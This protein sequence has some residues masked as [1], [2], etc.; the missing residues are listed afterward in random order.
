MA[1]LGRTIGDLTRFRREWTRLMTGAALRATL[2][3]APVQGRL[4][5]TA[6]FGSNPG[7]LRMFSYMPMKRRRAPAL[8]VVLH[9]CKQ[10]AAGYDEGS[11]WST[12]ADRYGFA[13]LL[14]EQR[15]TNN[16]HRCFNWFV[17][18]DTRRGKGEALSIRQMI[19]RMVREHRID[20]RR[21]FVT[22]LSAGA[23]MTS[24]MLAAYPETFA[25]GGIIAGMPYG[26]AGSTAEALEAMFR[27]RERPAEDWAA[28]VRQ[29]SRHRGP[30]PRVSVW[31]GTADETV[32]PMNAGEIVKQWTAVHG[33][34]GKPSFEEI[35]DGHPRRVW[36]RGGESLVEEYSISGM[37]HGTPLAVGAGSESLGAA[38][39]FMLDAGIASSYHIAKFWGLV[40]N[41][42]ASAGIETQIDAESGGALA[43]T[44]AEPAHNFDD[45][46]RA[47][48]AA[49]RGDQSATYR[50]E[51]IQAA[52]SRALKAAGLLD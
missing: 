43:Q 38:G 2:P 20:R 35:V 11:G 34:T 24:V 18:E 12:L 32:R 47:W 5:E 44:D 50:L 41:A 36:G 8:V 37:A 14:P 45:L 6:E 17:P 40:P 3:A 10:D 9:G 31:H 51:D 15:S 52:V 28:L 23:A 13:L 42:T 16:A 22:G 21:V 29:A 48:S 27:G 39:P 7:N 19:A 1:G 26:A 46:R 25:G 30:W 33:L 4:R 49:P